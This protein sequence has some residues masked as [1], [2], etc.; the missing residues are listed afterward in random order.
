M[1]NRNPILTYIQ[2][3][4]QRSVRKD[5]GGSG[6][7][8]VDLPFP[9]T[10]PC[11]PG[12]GHFDFLC[13]W[14]TYFTNLGLLRQ[15]Q[16]GLALDNIRNIV[17]LVRRQGYMPNHVGLYNRSQVPYLCRMVK[18]YLALTGDESHLEEMADGLRQEYNFWMT[19]RFTTTGLNRYGHQE[20][21]DGCIKFYNGPAVSYSKDIGQVA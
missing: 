17:W 13:Y 10:P 4:W 5:S 1:Q 8:G 19:A 16:S 7:K 2:N 9:Y 15:G 21:A 6:F 12:E 3:S 14:D 20:T 11:I 18:D